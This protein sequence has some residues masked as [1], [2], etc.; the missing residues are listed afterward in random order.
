MSKCIV[1]KPKA[2]HVIQA[3]MLHNSKQGN[4]N[5]TKIILII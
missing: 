2:K 1:G 4:I 3:Y 5:T